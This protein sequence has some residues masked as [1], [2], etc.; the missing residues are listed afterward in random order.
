MKFCTNCNEYIEQFQ[1][2]GKAENLSGIL[3]HPDDAEN[4][5]AFPELTVYNYETV[6][7]TYTCA[8]CGHEYDDNEFQKLES[9]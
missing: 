1:V 8:N 4:N 2:E 6:P 7:E 9:K 3:T 5:D